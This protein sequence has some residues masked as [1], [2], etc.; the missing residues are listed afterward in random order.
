MYINQSVIK[1]QLLTLFKIEDNFYLKGPYSVN[2]LLAVLS[3]FCQ[4][5]NQLK[6]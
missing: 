4:L 3:T 1:L 5:M 6:S 2:N